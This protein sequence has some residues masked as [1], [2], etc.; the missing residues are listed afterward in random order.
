M[1]DLDLPELEVPSMLLDPRIPDEYK[2]D[3]F[4][5]DRHFISG[6]RF[7]EMIINNHIRATEILSR[8]EK[9]RA[10]IEKLEME[11]NSEK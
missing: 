9:V 8:I 3:D 2:L 5:L 6:V 7:A 4:T 10:A 1:K 11:N